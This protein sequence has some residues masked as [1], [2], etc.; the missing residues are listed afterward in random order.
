MNPEMKGI[1]V[2]GA[3][4]SDIAEVY[5]TAAYRVGSLV[6]AAGRPLVSGGGRG[7]LMAA[8]IEGA[9]DAEGEAIGILPDFMVA[10][11]WQHDRLTTMLT[12]P[13]MHT[14]KHTMARMS[15]GVIALPG[16]VGTLDE[17]MEI[18][19]WRQLGLYT[20]NVVILNTYGYYDPLLQMLA[21]IK[22]QGFMRGS[23]EGLWSVASTADEAVETALK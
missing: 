4:C 9:V 10:K 13:D 18:I 20:G 11:G 14:R 7:G 6:A 17:L 16:G 12:A 5:K 15:S 2:Y 8:A 23:G 21:R 22:E 3:S 19:T 1:C